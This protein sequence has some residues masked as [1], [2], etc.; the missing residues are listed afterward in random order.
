MQ[1]RGLQ[2]VHAEWDTSKR[3]LKLRVIMQ[4]K[5]LERQRL[6]KHFIS[7]CVASR[8]DLPRQVDYNIDHDAVPIVSRKS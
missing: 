7:T 6:R 2:L 1:Q 3:Q 8:A 5:E 4:V